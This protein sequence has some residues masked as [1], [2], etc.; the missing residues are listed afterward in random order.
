VSINVKVHD[1][2]MNYID[3]AP[4]VAFNPKFCDI[5]H[6]VIIRQNEMLVQERAYFPNISI[7]LIVFELAYC[8]LKIFP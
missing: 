3:A 4:H 5:T 8:L 6:I 7:G 1:F 2:K